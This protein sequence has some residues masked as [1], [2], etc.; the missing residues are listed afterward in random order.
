LPIP[1]DYKFIF[2]NDLWHPHETIHASGIISEINHSELGS[3]SE[4]ETKGLDYRISLNSGEMIE[5][6]AEENPGEIYNEGINISNW[7]FT[8]KIK[9]FEILELDAI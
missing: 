8:V 2:H 5:V 7:V 1:D 9:N 3:I 6:E 4:I